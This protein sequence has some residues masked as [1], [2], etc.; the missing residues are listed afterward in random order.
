METEELINVG[1]AV[2]H[3]N[4]RRVKNRITEQEGAVVGVEG[5]ALTV[6]LAEALEVWSSRD[7]D[8]IYS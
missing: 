4:A 3:G 1:Q 6:Q 8:E 7:C 5:S 2:T